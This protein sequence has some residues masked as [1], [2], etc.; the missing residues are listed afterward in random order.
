METGVVETEFLLQVEQFDGFS[1]VEVSDLTELLGQQ[2][3]STVRV[4]DFCFPVGV[5]KRLAE[6]HGPVIR[7][8]DRIGP[9]TQKGDDGIREGVSAGG[10]V[11]GDRHFPH[12]DFD[13]GQNALRN[14]FTSDSK[15]GCMRGMTVDDRLDVG[16]VFHDCQVK[17]NFAGALSLTSDLNT[18]HIDGTD[19]IRRHEPFADHGR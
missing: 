12:K 4:E 7:E 19:V 1:F 10:F 3:N 11:R 16:P 8:D 5:L 17:Q 15:G 9:V 14:R 6:R 13:L 18:F 2:Q